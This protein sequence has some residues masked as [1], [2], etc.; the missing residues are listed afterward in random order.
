M[1][2][3][4][5]LHPLPVHFPTVFVLSLAIFDCIAIVRD[6]RID[7]RGA[8]VNLSTGLVMCAGITAAFIF[9]DLASD[10]AVAAGTPLAQLET[11]EESGTITVGI[12]SVWALVR[13]VI[14]W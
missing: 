11:H 2:A 13:C 4:E 5:Q 8:I 7:G 1:L 10:V 14:W 6:A 3:I 9:G 12:L